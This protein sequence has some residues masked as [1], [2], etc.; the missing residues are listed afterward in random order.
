MSN[1]TTAIPDPMSEAAHPPRSG[2]ADKP[3]L[4]RAIQEFVTHV[5]SLAE[6][7]PLAMVAINLGKGLAAAHVAKYAKQEP[8]VTPTNYL[9]AKRTLKR[10]DKASRAATLVTQ[11]FLVSM[12][13]QYDAFLGAILRTLYVL[14]P[15]LLNISERQITYADLVGFGSIQSARDHILEKEVETVLRKSHSEQFDWLESKFALPLRKDLDVWPRFVELTER[16]NLFVHA[17]GIVSQQYLDVCSKHGVNHAEA[18]T[19]GQTLEVT[20]SYFQEAYDCIIEIGVKLAHTL[21]RKVLPGDRA[22]AD[23]NLNNVCYETYF[24]H[25]SH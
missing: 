21:W 14:R 18:V 24:P 17:S 8:T 16:R 4:G 25:I 11:S 23:Q 5:D 9:R 7:L 12:V 1:D 22:S 19:R 3:Q 2:P 15:E 20:Q 6:T 13:S 10:F